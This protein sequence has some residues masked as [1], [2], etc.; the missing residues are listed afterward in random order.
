MPI[1]GIIA[2]GIS[3]NLYGITGSY[4]SIA[5]V[6]VGSGGSSSIT[7]SSIPSTYTHL[8]IRA[9]T[10]VSTTARGGVSFNGDTTLSNYENHYLYGDGASAAAGTGAS[11]WGVVLASVSSSSFGGFVAD[12]LDYTSANKNKVWRSLSGQDTN[13][14]GY[15]VLYSGVW[16]NTNAITSLTLY[17]DEDSTSGGTFAQY[18]HFALYGI[19]GA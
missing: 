15:L 1:L 13:G 4:E 11:S 5:T 17:P 3:G 14:G 2:S 16:L 9:I 18:S 7:F 8:Q 10:Q 12:I 6:T 19:K